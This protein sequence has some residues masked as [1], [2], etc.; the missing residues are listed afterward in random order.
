MPFNTIG[1]KSDLRWSETE[2]PKKDEASL[3]EA[4]Y[5][6][7]KKQKR[8][9]GKNMKLEKPNKLNGVQR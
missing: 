1:L 7:C 6:A 8:G 3:M 5:F 2:M 9:G 4:L